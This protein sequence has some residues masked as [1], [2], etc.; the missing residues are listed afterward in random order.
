M[1]LGAIFPQNEIGNDPSAIREWAET[2]EGLG[3]DH[4]LATP[5]DHVATLRRT[6]ESESG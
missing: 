3:Y 4:I 2:A 6:R 1:R 5:Q